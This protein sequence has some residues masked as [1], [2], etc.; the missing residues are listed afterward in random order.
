MDTECSNEGCVDD[1]RGVERGVGG[2]E[3][4][5]REFCCCI[6][7]VNDFPPFVFDFG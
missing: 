3:F 6:L 7:A 2:G 5:Y 4:E 1:S